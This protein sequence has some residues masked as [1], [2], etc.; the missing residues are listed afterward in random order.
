M[1]PLGLTIVGFPCNQ[2]GKQEPGQKHEILPALKWEKYLLMQIIIRSA[3]TF[4]WVK[5][6]Q[7]QPIKQLGQ[8]QVLQ[9]GKIFFWEFKCFIQ[10]EV[11]CRRFRNIGI[12]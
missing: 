9:M 3:A 5:T 12:S 4:H 7:S 6:P 8:S 1:K 2:F 11:A 10:K